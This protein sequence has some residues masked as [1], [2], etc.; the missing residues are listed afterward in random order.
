MHL[1]LY[2]KTLNRLSPHIKKQLSYFNKDFILHH[3]SALK[4]SSEHR[5]YSNDSITITP[6]TSE[7]NRKNHAFWIFRTNKLRQS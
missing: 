7:P 2:E 1:A 6:Q 5:L 4:K 3:I